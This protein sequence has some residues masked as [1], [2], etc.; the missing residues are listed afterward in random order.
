MHI[1]MYDM[2]IQ[3]YIYI[4]GY[5]SIYIYIYV[6][7]IIYILGVFRNAEVPEPPGNVQNCLNY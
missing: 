4:C 3:K 6:Y 5:I 2:C 7:I 1:T